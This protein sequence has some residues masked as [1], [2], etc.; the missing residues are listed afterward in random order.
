MRFHLDNGWQKVDPKLK[1]KFPDAE[2]WKKEV[3]RL[4]NEER[5]HTMLIPFEELSDHDK[6]KDHDSIRNY[7]A[8]AKLVGWKIAFTKD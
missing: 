2:L 3:K 7:P 6:E 1:D 4:K 8:M 5:R